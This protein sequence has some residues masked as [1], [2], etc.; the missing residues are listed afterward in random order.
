MPKKLAEEPNL[1]LTIGIQSNSF[2]APYLASGSGLVNISGGYTLSPNGANGRRIQE[3]IKRAQNVRVLVRGAKIYADEERHQPSLSAINDAV[4]P[5]GLRIDPHDCLTI[6][7]HG[8]PPDLEITIAG[9][10]SPQPRS[11]DTSYLATC[12]LVKD[13]VDHT[14]QLEALNAADRVL[15]RVEDACPV[16]FQ[17]RRTPTEFISGT[18]LRRYINT[19]VIVW[20]S[21]GWVKYH[22]PTQ[23]D[24]ITFLG[25]QSDWEKKALAI[26]CGRRWGHFYARIASPPDQL[27]IADPGPQRSPGEPPLR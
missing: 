2:I 23:A 15:D 19:D 5:F 6:T 3:L 12:L 26:D 25:K 20:V 7:L 22:Q 8:L 16:L 17:P 10:P 14:L 13:T 24:H 1:F 11:A 9:S 21:R 27:Q 4:T 18:A